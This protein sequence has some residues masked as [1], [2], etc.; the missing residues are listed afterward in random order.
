MTDIAEAGD[1]PTG[2]YVQ[3]D[4][5]SDTGGSIGSVTVFAICA[6]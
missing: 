1:I 6:S 5:I 4:D 2:W 3:W